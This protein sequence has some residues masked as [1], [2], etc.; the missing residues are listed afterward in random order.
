MC[1]YDEIFNII[2]GVSLFSF[3]IWSNIK[4][5]GYEIILRIHLLLHCFDQIYCLDGVQS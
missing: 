4:P 5:S 2:P 1:L 3:L